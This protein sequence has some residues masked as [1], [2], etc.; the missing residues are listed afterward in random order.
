MIHPLSLLLFPAVIGLGGGADSRACT[1]LP[2]GSQGLERLDRGLVVARG[3]K[4][5]SYFASWRS[6]A[7]DEPD[8]RFTLLRDGKPYARQ[9]QQATS[10]QVSGTPHSLWQVVAVHSD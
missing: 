1:S 3:E 4:A 8:L 2:Q 6:L 9:P 5:G 10:M 7:G